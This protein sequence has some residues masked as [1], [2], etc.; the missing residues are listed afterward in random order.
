MK[1]QQFKLK[2]RLHEVKKN[3]KY[4]VEMT[5]FISENEIF[6]VEAGVGT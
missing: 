1:E 4:K 3:M 5:L 2:G 6:R